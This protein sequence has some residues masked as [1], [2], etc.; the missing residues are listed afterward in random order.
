MRTRRIPVGRTIVLGLYLL[1]VLLPLGSVLIAS[2]SRSGA[3]LHLSA[4]AI[5]SDLTIGHYSAALFERRGLQGLI[6]S[7]IVSVAATILSTIVGAMTAYSLARYRTGA[8]FLSL[9]LLGLRFLPPIILLLP[10]FL[11]YRALGL[12]DTHI[13]LIL[14]Y[15]M[16]T[17]PLTTW[18]IYSYLRDVPRSLEDAARIDGCTHLQALW[19]VSAPLAV[20]GLVA[21]ATFAFIACWTDFLIAL[22]LTDSNAFTLQT[23]FE[24]FAGP[25]LAHPG[26]A[27]ALAIV[28]LVLPV[29]LGILARRHL[30]RALTLGAIRR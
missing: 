8:P 29:T 18:L 26:E 11:I 7:A 6:N 17:L 1:F 9:W 13:G 15:T 25:Q 14:A 16:F 22:A 19:R 10:L 24:D 2:I 28:S 5:P 4:A 30:V 23:V 21:A 3:P 12:H 27:S 20:P